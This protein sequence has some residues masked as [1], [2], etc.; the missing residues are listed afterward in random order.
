MSSPISN[1]AHSPIAGE[2]ALRNADE[3][4]TVRRIPWRHDL[5]IISAA[6]EIDTRSVRLLQRAL[7]QDLPAGLVINLS[8]VTYFGVA[9]VRALEGAVSRACAERRRIGIV[10]ATHAVLGPLRISG[11]DTRVGVYP[12][13][14]DALREVPTSPPPPPATPTGVAAPD[15]TG[16]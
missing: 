2:S 3:V 16:A 1:S 7:W 5:A 9:G 13:L 10:A 12:L 8:E 14:A 15:R 6:G 11:L 4:L